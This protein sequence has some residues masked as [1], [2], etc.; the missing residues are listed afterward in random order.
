MTTIDEVLAFCFDGPLP[1]CAAELQQWL[2]DSRRFKA[3]V[4]NHRVKI[5]AKLKGARD[6]AG[7]LDVL[8]ELQTAALILRDDRFTLEYERYAAAR[9]RGPDFTATYRTHT[10]CNVEVRRIRSSELQEGNASATANKLAA[11]LC[12]KVGQMPPSIIN[13]L[14]LESGGDITIEDLARTAAALRQRAESKDEA[15]FRRCDCKDA[16]HF[17]KQYGQLSAIVLH[18]AGGCTVWLNPLARHRAPPDIVAAIQRLQ[19]AQE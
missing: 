14:W 16:A 11:V 4:I 18:R 5:R 13:L 9:Q 6:E 12:D 10:L 15:F 7:L 3:F 8:A 2:R 17:L 19:P 1:P